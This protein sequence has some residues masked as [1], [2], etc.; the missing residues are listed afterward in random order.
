MHGEESALYHDLHIDTAEKGKLPSNAKERQRESFQIIR[1]IPSWQLRVGA[2]VDSSS[3]QPF[4]IDLP[5]EEAGGGGLGFMEVLPDGNVAVD[6]TLAN[7][8][9]ME[10]GGEEVGTR[11]RLRST[12]FVPWHP[13]TSAALPMGS[14]GPEGPIQHLGALLPLHWYVHSSS[15]PAIFSLEHT[16]LSSPSRSGGSG[17]MELNDAV[18][19]GRGLLHVEK[20]WGQA[21]PSGWMWAHGASPLPDPS[22]TS[23]SSQPAA[24][25][26]L[27]GG[28]ILGLTAFLVGIHIQH[29]SETWDWNFTPPFA[30]GPK[31]TLK[32]SPGERVHIGPGLHMRRDFA[33]KTFTLDVWTPTQWAHIE[34]D[35]DEHTFATQIPGPRKGGW[36]PGYCHHSYRCR[37]KIA[38]YQRSLAATVTLPLRAAVHP[39]STLRTCRRFLARPVEAKEK[40]DDEWSSF[41]WYKV[42]EAQLPD[43]VALEFGGDFAQ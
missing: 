28:S 21:F 42:V 27:A 37:A 26:S 10:R 12:K 19:A 14:R 35:G 36:S 7:P 4:R 16:S 22:Y 20:N 40:E 3:V 5:S 6:L 25:L 1:Y 31:H 29:G 15:A 39:I 33:N 9:R 38:L 24:R 30:L 17:D 34:I 23:S 13:T 18:A 41:G 32:G 43:R 11:L 2:R 8:S